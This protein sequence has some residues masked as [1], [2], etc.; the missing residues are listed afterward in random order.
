MSL[1]LIIFVLVLAA[2]VL[3]L[4]GFALKFFIKL[5]LSERFYLL[6]QEIQNSLQSNR[7]ENSETLKNTLESSTRLLSE[8]V[9]Y[10]NQTISQNLQ[11]INQQVEKKLSQ[12]FEK[13]NATFTD[14]VKRLALIDQAQQKI[15]DL[16]TN[17]VSLKEILQDKRSRGAFGEIQ[18][19]TLIKNLLPERTFKF[20]HTL[21]NGKRCDCILFLPDPTGNIVID[22]KFPLENF[23]KMMS[24]DLGEFD[25]KIAE[26][27]F[28]KDIKT[29]IQDISSKY[30]LPGETAEGAVMFIPAEAIFAEIHSYYPEL[31]DLSYQHKV[32]LASPT[33]MMAILTTAKAVLK[34]DAT[35]R[36]VHVIQEHLGYLSKDFDRF[37]KRMDDLERH[38]S[39][40]N[41]DVKHINIS[42]K[43][44]SSRFEKIESVDLT[45]SSDFIAPLPLAGETD[46]ETAGLLG[47]RDGQD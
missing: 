35:K 24:H 9:Q 5:E 17:V 13:T 16:S 19:E 42:A 23:Q 33:T 38:I 25:K 29:H 18:L 22:S 46:L 26:Q 20:Q 44:I 37:Q 8:R 7:K 30:I 12:G 2:L 15:S 47:Q 41:D 21:S 40:A 43:K 3:I 4:L 31:V 11:D 34:D 1:S 14:I 10:L 6:S 39:Q 28:R 45:H 27:N 32:W 36:Q